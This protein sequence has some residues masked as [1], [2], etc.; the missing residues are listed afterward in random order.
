MPAPK[1]CFIHQTWALSTKTVIKR[2]RRISLS[3]K[4]PVQQTG[5][6]PLRFHDRV[7]RPMSTDTNNNRQADV[8][9]RIARIMQAEEQARRK[10]VTQEDVRT[11]RAAAC[12]LDRLLDGVTGKAAMPE[13]KLR[14]SRKD[15]T[16]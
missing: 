3:Q 6:V 4:V 16:E 7:C 12:R 13:L 8:R 11:L 14:R 9:Y 15:T 2:Y 5:R 1:P 10:E